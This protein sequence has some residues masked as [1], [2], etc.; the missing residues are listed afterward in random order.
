M[1][2]EPPPS[3]SDRHTKAVHAAQSSS[4]QSLPSPQLWL[5]SA[6]LLDSVE[7]GWEMLTNESIPNTA[8]QRYANPTTLVLEQKFAA[9]EGA[10]FALTVNSGMTA[11]YL[12][13][14]ALLRTGDHVVACHSLYHEISDQFRF[15]ECGAG[16]AYSL[17]A[18]YSVDGF[19]RELRPNT[20]MVFIESPT[21]PSMFDVDIAGLAELCRARRVLFA[22]DNTL[23]THEYQKPLDLGA[24]V[25]VYSTTKAING[26]GDCMG[27]VL[28]CNDGEI[29]A[30]LR[31]LR[32]NA[33]LV[34]DPFSAWLTTRGL[35]T[36]PLRLARHSE[37]AAKVIEFIEAKYPMLDVRHPGKCPNHVRNRVTGT[38][39][40]LSIALPSKEQGE[41]FMRALQLI[42]IGTTFGNLE[43]LVYHFGTFARPTREIT[44][45]GIPLGLVRL[46]I[47]IEDPE[48]IIEDIDRGLHASLRT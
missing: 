32:E 1:E 46:S 35:R 41:R 17:V 12:L 8:Y 44:K 23:L 38:G 11:C 4:A 6:V 16:V 9:M 29:A 10:Q 48:D 34:L 5:N 24:D 18:D 14:R 27:G 31:S 39:G 40:I 13:F 21:N 15:D 7:Q 47:G 37:N 26:H 20:R 43:S 33:G 19:R 42:R 30:K 2:H 22:V 45:I 36:L 3:A 25:A 28:S